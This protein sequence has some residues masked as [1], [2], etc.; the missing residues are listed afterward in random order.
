MDDH[1]VH[2]SA[3][4]RTSLDNMTI[5]PQALG[6]SASSSTLNH[7]RRV[8]QPPLLRRQ[9]RP[10]GSGVATQP[11]R[12]SERMAEPMP[13]RDT[14]THARAAR[15][16]QLN[17][18][19]RFAPTAGS[20]AQ[21]RRSAGHGHA[22]PFTPGR[23]SLTQPNHEPVPPVRRARPHVHTPVDPPA[24]TPR[25]PAADAGTHP[26]PPGTHHKPLAVL[27]GDNGAKVTFVASKTLPGT[28]VASGSRTHAGTGEARTR[29]GASTQHAAGPSN[30]RVVAPHH[31]PHVP[32]HDE[33]E[34]ESGVDDSDR[35]VAKGK[36]K[37]TPGFS[38]IAELVNAGR[39]ANVDELLAEYSKPESSAE[40]EDWVANHP[41]GPFDP[42][43]ALELVFPHPYLQAI[44]EDKFPTTPIHR[45]WG[46]H[47]PR[48]REVALFLL[49]SS[50]SETTL[51]SVARRLRSAV[52]HLDARPVDYDFACAHCV[53]FKIPCNDVGRVACFECVTR[54]GNRSASCG[55]TGK[56]A[57]TAI[58]VVDEDDAEEG[59]GHEAE[60]VP[61]TPEA[62]EV[63]APKVTARAV[64]KPEVA[65]P[66]VIAPKV[67]AP[68][69]PSPTV[70][71]PTATAPTAPTVA[72]PIV[73]DPIDKDDE[74]THLLTTL[75]WHMLTEEEDESRKERADVLFQWLLETSGTN[76]TVEG[77]Y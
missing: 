39:P 49:K 16:P 4:R 1:V 34:A 53:R 46:P 65:A 37:A 45:G 8:A 29:A 70:A 11:H 27:K 25:A 7:P 47:L 20:S 31:A 75:R 17:G 40:L 23:L 19:V 55:R 52:G 69:V 32:A 14:V 66:K 22:S 68:K 42:E 33:S 71:R 64:A 77:G 24:G 30:P 36:Q 59:G 13:L 3:T 9:P 61:G 41:Y 44:V 12:P 48:L 56:T 2:S 60:L 35:A 57:A 63:A 72:A 43:L 73:G 28:P 26:K 21:R 10:S 58:R 54:G 5:G 18:P 51:V 15:T 67:V 76:V 38:R 6:S 74:T 62:V 50:S